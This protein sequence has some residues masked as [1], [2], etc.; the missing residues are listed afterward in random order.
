V[1]EKHEIKADVKR[2]NGVQ[3]GGRVGP[4]ERN[5]ISDVV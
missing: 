2:A 4:A 5:V 3:G 1:L